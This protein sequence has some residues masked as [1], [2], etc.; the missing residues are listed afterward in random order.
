[1]KKASPSQ[2]QK[3]DLPSSKWL[4]EKSKV[5]YI[6]L[7]I[8]VIA[9]LLAATIN[10]CLTNKDDKKND[11]ASVV[12]IK[13]SPNTVNSNNLT[14]NYFLNKPLYLPFKPIEPEK[15]QNEEVLPTKRDANLKPTSN[16]YQQS[17]QYKF[18]DNGGYDLVESKPKSRSLPV[19]QSP[20]D[21]DGP[22]GGAPNYNTVRVVSN[23]VDNGGYDNVEGGK[24]YQANGAARSYTINFSPTI[25]VSSTINVGNV[26]GATATTGA[27]INTIGDVDGTGGGETNYRK[28]F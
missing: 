2:E 17:N 5:V 25:T 24:Q 16:H 4:N 22:G 10:Y 23:S 20:I 7:T 28:R 21:V 27:I 12:E 6:P 13:N 9:V 8:A 19:R 11:K 18:E 15:S 3:S 14:I 26:S 1:M